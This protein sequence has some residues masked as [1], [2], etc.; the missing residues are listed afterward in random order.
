MNMDWIKCQRN[1][2]CKTCSDYNKCND[3]IVEKKKEKK[4]KPKKKKSR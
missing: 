4:K 2:I 1:P 3:G